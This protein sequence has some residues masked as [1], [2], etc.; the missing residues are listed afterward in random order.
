MSRQ[1]YQL[2]RGFATLPGFLQRAASAA[3]GWVRVC[4][5]KCTGRR[6]GA[7]TASCSSCLVA[8]QQCW[9]CVVAFREHQMVLEQGELVPY[10]DWRVNDV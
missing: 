5:C 10:R 3:R 7:L 1:P 6:I 2:D 4:G 9:G 8:D